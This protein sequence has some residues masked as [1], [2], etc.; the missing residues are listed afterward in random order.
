M[1]INCSTSF[2]QQSSMAGIAA[3][4]RDHAGNVI[5]V[6]C[7]FMNAL[8]SRT[9][10]ALAF[11]LGCDLIVRN[12]WSAFIIESSNKGLINSLNQN[13]LS[14]WESKSVE[15]DISKFVVSRNVLFT[16]VKQQ[17]NKASSWLA[18]KARKDLWNSVDVS[19]IPVI[20]LQLLEYDN[21]VVSVD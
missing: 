11:R 1:K 5:D 21:H 2:N 4:A 13:L 15:L 14:S 3:I 19:N 17:A 18:K 12:G 7:N 6:S 20:L 9:A 10:D 16:H 8:S